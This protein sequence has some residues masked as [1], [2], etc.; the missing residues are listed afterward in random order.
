MCLCVL[1]DVF[2]VYIMMSDDG[3]DVDWILDS[4]LDYMDWKGYY[5]H[6]GLGIYVYVG[7]FRAHE[8]FVQF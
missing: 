4:T 7:G 6:N 1:I 5:I 2:M 8:I 3:L